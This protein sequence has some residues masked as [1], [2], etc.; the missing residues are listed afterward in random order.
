MVV[1]FCPDILV[2]LLPPYRP[3]VLY[4]LGVTDSCMPYHVRSRIHQQRR[5][6]AYLAARACDLRVLKQTAMAGNIV[7]NCRRREASSVE[8][9]CSIGLHGGRAGL[10]ESLV[11]A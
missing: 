9:N 6:M 3:H 7:V 2:S 11:E 10:L 4:Y 1:R 8:L 5:V